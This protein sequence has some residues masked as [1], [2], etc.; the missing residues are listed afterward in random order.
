MKIVSASQQHKLKCNGKV[1]SGGA[2]LSIK[3]ER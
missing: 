1:E 3:M 2:E